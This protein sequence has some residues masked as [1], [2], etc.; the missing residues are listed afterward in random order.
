MVVNNIIDLSSKEECIIRKKLVFFALLF[1]VLS[2]SFASSASGFFGQHRT[3]PRCGGLGRD[4]ATLFLTSCPTCGGD[5]EVGIFMDDEDLEDGLSFLFVG[6]I[7]I[8]VIA[9]VAG[10]LS[11]GRK[12]HEISE[13][14]NYAM[15]PK[16]M[17]KSKVEG[18]FFC[19]YC[20]AENWK[21][22]VYCI[23]CGKKI[24]EA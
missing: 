2:M 22:A 18:K 9:G 12:S 24:G 17:A 19:R 10:G 23:K 11:K 15:K 4:P 8:V 3:C 1:L 14:L 13:K 16:V 21:E 20:G 6:V 5:G 7:V